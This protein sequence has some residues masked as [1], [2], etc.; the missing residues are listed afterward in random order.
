MMLLRN[1]HLGV[2]CGHIIQEQTQHR[3]VLQTRSFLTV[4]QKYL[5][6]KKRYGVKNTLWKLYN[7][8][9]VKFGR[10]VGED[11]NGFKYYEDPSELY[12]QHRWTEYKVDSWD[13]VEGTLIPP[14][15][16]LWMH[17]MTD[18][19]PGENGQDPTQWETSDIVTHSDAP[20]A[21]HLGEYGP[22]YPNKTLYRSRGYNVGS[23]AT[24]PDEVDQYYLQPGHLRRTR[25][26]KQH[27][28]ADVDYNNPQHSDESRAQSLRPAD[29]N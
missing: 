8:G 19:V 20:F 22:Y 10:F 17:H 14:E 26:R 21:T 16:H 12:G 1:R 11:T 18:S 28:F 24:K 29:V 6:A 13:E 25:K 3:P 9:E 23:L 7:L 15:W 4:F 2:T 27:F 5:E